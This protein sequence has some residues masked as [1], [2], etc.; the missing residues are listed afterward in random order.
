MVVLFD[1]VQHVVFPNIAR[2]RVE[3]LRQVVGVGAQALLHPNGPV[4]PGADAVEVDVGLVIALG[5]GIHLEVLQRLRLPAV[6]GEAE[7][8]VGGVALLPRLPVGIL[9]GQQIDVRSVGAAAPHLAVLTQV[10]VDELGHEHR[11]RQFFRVL[12]LI[13]AAGRQTEQHTRGQ[14]RRQALFD[15]MIH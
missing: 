8:A 5:S 11:A 2:L 7:D 6:H 4:R 10:H 13:L 3:V 14:Q 12:V 15:P 1:A 9:G